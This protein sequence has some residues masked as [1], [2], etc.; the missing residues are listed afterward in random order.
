VRE[1]ARSDVEV[2]ARRGDE[3]L[4]H[5]MLKAG[6]GAFKLDAVPDCLEFRRRARTGRRS[7]PVILCD[8]A[9]EAKPYI[10][11]PTAE[12]NESEGASAADDADGGA[13]PTAASDTSKAG[14]CSSAPG[15]PTTVLPMLIGLIALPLGRRRRKR[16][17]GDR[18][19]R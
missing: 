7:A 17:C 8:E 9:L 16:L 3:T 15:A 11:P 4:L 18:A 2:I 13:A 12:P 6:D 10:E 19:S 5:W 1:H 14:G